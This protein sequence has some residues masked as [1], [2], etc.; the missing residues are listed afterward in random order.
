MIVPPITRELSSYLLVASLVA[1]CVERSVAR[2]FG[3]AP[4][5]A[6]T[7]VKGTMDEPRE[8]LMGRKVET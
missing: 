8:V 5:S 2:Q 1:E 7:D 6:R 4:G 3:G